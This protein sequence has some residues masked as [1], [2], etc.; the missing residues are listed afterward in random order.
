M[1][2]YARNQQWGE[3]PHRSEYFWKLDG[4]HVAV[5]Y[6]AKPVFKDGQITGAVISFSDISDKR[7][8]EVELRHAQKLEAVGRLAAG[9]AHEIN[10]PNPIH[11]RQYPLSPGLLWRKASK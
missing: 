4:S 3:L 9:I 7:E 6:S 5:D 1:R 8:M 10:T 11:R 2:G